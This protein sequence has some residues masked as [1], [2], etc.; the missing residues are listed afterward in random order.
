M[1]EH[2]ACVYV[3]NGQIEA[4]QVKDFLVGHGVVAVL[5]G[6]SLSKTHALTVDGLGRVEVVVATSDAD[7]ARMLIASADAGEFRL[8]D[9]ADVEQA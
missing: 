4:H 5:R 2:T 9:D 3:A 1:D 6:E 8:G 7:R